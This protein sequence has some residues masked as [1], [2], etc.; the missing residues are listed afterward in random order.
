MTYKYAGLAFYQVF[1]PYRLLTLKGFGGGA[2]YPIS[3]LFVASQQLFNGFLIL[4]GH[5][6]GLVEQDD[7]RNV[8]ALGRHQITINQVVVGFRFGG[9]HK[10]DVVNIGS[11]G[12]ECAEVVGPLQ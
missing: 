11:D 6:I 2:F 5:Q 10:D 4:V 3:E 12:L 8:R 1:N 7:D 9:D